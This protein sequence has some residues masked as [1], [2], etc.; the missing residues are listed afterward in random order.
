MCAC[1]R[2]VF[3]PQWKSA[4]PHFRACVCGCALFSGWWFWTVEA[5]FKLST[6]LK[7]KVMAGIKNYS[8]AQQQQRGTSTPEK[9]FTFGVIRHWL[10]GWVW[11]Q[12]EED[13]QS[14][15]TIYLRASGGLLK[16]ST[17]SKTAYENMHEWIWRKFY[18]LSERKRRA[19]LSVAKEISFT[20]WGARE[21][22]PDVSEGVTPC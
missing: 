10:V 2:L 22:A 5:T 8:R 17:Y 4:T 11:F 9:V 12:G 14:Q 3:P 13:G 20:L 18:T 6:P 19:K 15:P 1:V 16:S 21:L 7:G